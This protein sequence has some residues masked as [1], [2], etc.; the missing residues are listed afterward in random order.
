MLFV[1][2]IWEEKRMKGI[3]EAEKNGGKTRGK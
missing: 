2:E 1:I 3:K